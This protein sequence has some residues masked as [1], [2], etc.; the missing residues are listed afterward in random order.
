MSSLAALEGALVITS[1]E[2]LP[3]AVLARGPARRCQFTTPRAH[4]GD[5]NI[6]HT[7]P[8][9]PRLLG[10]VRAFEATTRDRDPVVQ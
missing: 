2:V 6:Q 5:V 8:S 9:P 10:D 1:D 7:A 3:L 4:L